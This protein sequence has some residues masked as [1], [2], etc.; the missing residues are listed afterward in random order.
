MTFRFVSY[1]DGTDFFEATRDLDSAETLFITSSKTFTTLETMTNAH[2]ARLWSIARSGTTKNESLSCRE[3]GG[4]KGHTGRWIIGAM[5]FQVVP[6]FVDTK[7]EA[8]F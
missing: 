3:G 6:A 7:A 2:T 1:V 8:S 5:R 4:E